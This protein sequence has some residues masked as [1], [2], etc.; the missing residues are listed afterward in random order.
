M[1]KD[2]LKRIIGRNIRKYRLR[3]NTLDNKRLTQTQLA[4]L[5]GAKRSLIG[6]IESDN[7]SICIS[8]FNLYKISKVLN[9]RIDKF[10]EVEA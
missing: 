2:E 9:I 5:I 10:F 3:Y 7:S 6:A 4:E 8:V 1:K